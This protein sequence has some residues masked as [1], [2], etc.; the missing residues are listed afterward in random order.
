MNEQQLR[1]EIA[2]LGHTH[3]PSMLF[4]QEEIDSIMEPL[5]YQ[6]PEHLRYLLLSG[7]TIPVFNVLSRAYPPN[8]S[9]GLSSEQVLASPFSYMKHGTMLENL[10]DILTDGNLRSHLLHAVPRDDQYP[11]IYMSV[12][13]FGYSA[14][15]EMMMG[16]DQCDLIFSLSLFRRKDWHANMVEAYGLI[17]AGTYDSKTLAEYLGESFSLGNDIGEIVFHN[18]IPT[19][20]LEY[21][22]VND[23]VDPKPI[24]DKYGVKVYTYSQAKTLTR[25]KRVK[26]LYDPIEKY[27]PNFSYCHSSTFENVPSIKTLRYTLL[28]SGYT[29][30]QVNQLVSSMSYLELLNTVNDICKRIHKLG[31][32]YPVVVH[33]PY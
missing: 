12:K 20:Y 24:E 22:V 7:S 9:E 3:N 16:S 31:Y 23:S 29:T 19:R 30:D 10:D 6:I 4:T 32:T 26:G 25:R 27:H 8:D 13:G 2:L 14:K 17:G 15:D 21:I 5:T 33:P 28:N 11:G 1:D 18:P